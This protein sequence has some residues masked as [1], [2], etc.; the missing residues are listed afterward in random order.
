MATTEHFFTG[1][2]SETDYS[3]TFPYLNTADIKVQL[4]NVATTEYTLPTS[5]TVRFNTAPGTGVSIHIYRD[6]DVDTAK[7]I[8]AA[9][10]SVRA[11][12]L[13]NNKDQDLYT[14]Q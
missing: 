14:L 5:T 10:S 4:D 13:N 8:Y 2:N 11:V 7:A 1:D 12:D 3:F 6:T 9:G